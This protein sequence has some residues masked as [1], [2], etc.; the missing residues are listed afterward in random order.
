MFIDEKSLFYLLNVLLIAV[1]FK[2]FARL[3]PL[4]TVLHMDRDWMQQGILAWALIHSLTHSLTHRQ[5][6]YEDD[7]DAEC[8]MRAHGNWHM[9]KAQA[10]SFYIKAG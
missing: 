10:I 3:T 9:M 4:K 8:Q 1:L 2:W 5:A 7:R 6:V